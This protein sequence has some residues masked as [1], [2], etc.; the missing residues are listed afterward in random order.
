MSTDARWVADRTELRRLFRNHPTWANR[1]YADALHRSVSWVQKWRKRIEATP[2]DDTVFQSKSR[3]RHHPPPKVSQE[4]E[5]CVVHLRNNPPDGLKRIPGPVTI[6]ASL[7]RYRH[8]IPDHIHLPTSI[9]TIWRILRKHLCIELPD[10]RTHR[11]VERPAPM[12]RWA[13]DFKQCLDQ[14][15]E[16]NDKRQAAVECLNVVDEGTSIVVA[17]QVRSDFTAETALLTLIHIFQERGLPDMLVMDRDPRFV[18]GPSG[19]DFPSL[20]VRVL[21]NLGIQV[22]ICPPRRPDKN[23]FVERFHRS[24]EYECLRVYRPTS[25]EQVKEVIKNFREHY[26]HKRPNQA[27]TCRNLPPYEAFPELPSLR[28]L[29]TTI[30]PDRWVEVLDGKR[31]VRKVRANGTISIDNTQYYIGTAKQGCSLTFHING[32][33]RTFIVE[34]ADTTLKEIS[35]KGLIREALSVKDYVA[36][37]LREIRSQRL[38][39]QTSNRQL[40]FP[41]EILD[42]GTTDPTT[43]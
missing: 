35:I 10:V 32:A 3:A 38:S 8:L 14:L 25:L 31:F 4:A 26:N 21:H 7:K 9:S 11:P 36:L 42:T 40:A 18:G 5:Q 1:D 13:I 30:D 16:E 41:L 6:L 12:T 28:R 39:G 33:K 20:L 2:D 29:P 23:P 22:L 24:L 17:S 15:A 37:V 19:S 43:M 27:I 34:E